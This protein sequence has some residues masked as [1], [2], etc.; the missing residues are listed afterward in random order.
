MWLPQDKRKILNSD[1]DFDHIDASLRNEGT[2][3]REALVLDEDL[4]TTPLL[5]ELRAKTLRYSGGRGA[6]GRY[7]QVEV[8]YAG[9]LF[10]TTADRPLLEWC[11]RHGYVLLTCNVLD[12]ERLDRKLAHS[13]LIVSLDQ[14]FPSTNADDFATKINA[15]FGS[16]RKREFA[17]QLFTVAP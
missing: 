2:L 10:S 1:V 17:N 12:F 16:H 13:G 4:P 14:A 8:M 9:H 3:P 11:H 5:K 7:Q 6:I 15:I